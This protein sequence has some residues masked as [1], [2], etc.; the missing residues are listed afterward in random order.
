M[1]SESWRDRLKSHKYIRV[2]LNE[3]NRTSIYIIIAVA[4]FVIGLNIFFNNFI[5]ERGY[6][7]I[8]EEKTNYIL[9]DSLVIY[10]IK[11]L[12][13]IVLI[14]LVIGR[15]RFKDLGLEKKKI[16]PALIV[17]ISI[18]LF[19]Q[20]VGLIYT[21]SLNGSVVFDNAILDDG[22]NV[23]LGQTIAQIFGCGPYEEIV[24]RAFFIVQIYLLLKKQ[25]HE[26]P[27]KI[28]KKSLALSLL[29]TQIFFALIHI[30]NRIYKNQ[31]LNEY[32]MDMFSLFMYGIV[33]S[34]IYL[35]T[36]NILIVA[37]IH[38]LLNRTTSL[39]MPQFYGW[40]I[41]WILSIIIVVFYPIVVTR[42]TKENGIENSP[43]HP[44]S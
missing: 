9:Q 11:F 16:L 15:L 26:E 41:T 37:G 6:F 39:F 38:A 29:I 25:N 32:W 23:V 4:I 3:T 28:S 18:W 10:F 12:I 24:Y 30:P 13:I 21:F 40:I 43:S 1:K 8:I 19:Y 27:N 17:V 42:I 33:F 22:W 31:P 20:I 36:D 35:R 34:L 7:S 14:I 44:F 5:F 2:N